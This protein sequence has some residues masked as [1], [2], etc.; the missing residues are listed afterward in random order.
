M[1]LENILIERIETVWLR[2]FLPV[3]RVRLAVR[4]SG[5]SGAVDSFIFRKHGDL[6]QFVAAIDG[7]LQELVTRVLVILLEGREMR[8]GERTELLLKPQ[9]ASRRSDGSTV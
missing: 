7:K 3:R 2:T 5:G 9:D 6:A 4:A 1:Q 8:A